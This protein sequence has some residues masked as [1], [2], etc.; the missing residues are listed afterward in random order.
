LSLKLG[1]FGA[2]IGCSNYPDCRYTRPL[3]VNGDAVVGD[4]GT[5][6]V[7]VLGTDPDT[8]VDVTLRD[9]RFGPYVQL[10]NGEK[11]KRQGL[12]RGTTPD[13]VDLEMALKLLSLPRQV[14]IHPT[15]GQPIK[16]GI[17]R[18]GPYVQHEKTYASLGKDDDV[19]EIGA[20]RAIDLIVTKEQGGG[21]RFG[22]AAD[23]GRELGSDP[24]TGET[25]R[26]KSGRYGPYVTDGTTNA[27]LP[28]TTEPDAV[29][30][31]EA[32]ALISA[33]RA[34]GSS[35]RP[36]RGKAARKVEVDA[37]SAV[38]KAPS[39]RIAPP[40]KAAAPK[41]VSPTKAAASKAAPA[42][43]PSARKTPAKKPAKGPVKLPATKTAP[44]K[45]AARR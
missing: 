42:K 40:R 32:L 12:P 43:A 26:V 29:T 28:N 14:A 22:R 13:A 25:I 24:E 35:A 21:R 27:T 44:K 8:G 19:L 31:D 23:P 38:T 33:R 10:G 41:K 18:F 4:E 9:G 37:A 39:T 20:N 1:K 15:S 16:A 36:T 17:G 6:G 11:P 45:K 5:P 30:L 7:K 2:F 34:K 3:A